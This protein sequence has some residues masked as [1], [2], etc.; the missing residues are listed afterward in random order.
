M[1]H[2]ITPASKL[3][4]VIRAGPSAPA[5]TPRHALFR[6]LWDQRDASLLMTRISPGH[7]PARR[8]SRC[9]SSSPPAGL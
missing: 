8:S 9:A 1:N 6:A 7:R 3:L 2:A 5:G 4:G